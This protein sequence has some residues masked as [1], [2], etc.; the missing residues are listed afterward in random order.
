MA[1]GGFPLTKIGYLKRLVEFGVALGA[2]PGPNDADLQLFRE[3][4]MARPDDLRRRLLGANV[5]RRKCLEGRQRRALNV[6]DVAPDL[7]GPLGELRYEPSHSRLI[8]RFMQARAEPSLAPALLRAF[9]TVVGAPT[10]AGADAELAIVESER[11]LP[12]GRVDISITLPKHLVFVEMKVDAEEGEEQLAGYRKDLDAFSNGRDTLL[13][14]LTRP[15]AQD[16]V[17]GVDHVHVTLDQLL[18]SW[19]PFAGEGTGSEGYLARYLKSVA[20][21][22]RCAGHGTFDDWSITQQAAALDLVESI[23]S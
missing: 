16:S 17:S 9:L 22:V 3:R 4:I 7:L 8:A 13:V 5:Q 19:L 20:L 1:P 11:W 12:S 23:T 14:Y 21:V 18:V 15:G 2:T 6:L 10:A